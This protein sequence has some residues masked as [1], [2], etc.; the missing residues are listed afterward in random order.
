MRLSHNVHH[1]INTHRR[2]LGS[3]PTT[4]SAQPA[5]TATPRRHADTRGSCTR[6]SLRPHHNHTMRS[7]VCRHHTIINM[8]QAVPTPTSSSLPYRQYLALIIIITSAAL[9]NSGTLSILDPTSET[10]RSVRHIS[11]ATSS[12]QPRAIPQPTS[13]PSPVTSTTHYVNTISTS[14]SALPNVHTIPH[15]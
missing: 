6:P 4:A 10:Y 8:G 5:A 12:N 15:T 11:P 2:H 7:H 14:Q 9:L 13:P 1:I 3:T